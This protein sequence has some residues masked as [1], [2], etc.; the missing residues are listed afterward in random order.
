MQLSVQEVRKLDK[1]AVDELGLTGP[2]LMENA[3][4]GVCDAILR[5]PHH[6]KSIVLLCGPGN[7]GGDGFALA[8]QL[9]AHGICPQ[10]ILLAAGKDLTPDAG[11]NR[12][13]WQAAG[14]DVADELTP[15]E[16]GQ[17]LTALN[18]QDLIV[19]CL[20]GTG[21]RGAVRD[22]FRTVIAAA[23]SSEAPI[24]AVDLPSGMDA[25]SGTADGECIRAVQ[26]VTFVAPKTGFAAA[27]ADA[28]T[29]D[30][31]VAHIGLPLHWVTRWV[32]DLRGKA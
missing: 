27:G 24:L 11:F 4:R 15:E 28:F 20:L 29:G 22:P 6:L 9:S 26:T 1:A 16:I 32:D 23:N 5:L 21:I 14:G 19:D 8:R 2:I 10:V 17:R 31:H 7:N 12:Q 13:V 18:N 3:A 25:D 30:V